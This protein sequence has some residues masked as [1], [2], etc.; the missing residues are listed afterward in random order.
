LRVS[1]RDALKTRYRRFAEREAAGNS[2]LYERLASGIA[3]SDAALGFLL[4]LPSERRQPNL[5]LAALRVT[6]PMPASVG[7]LE[8]RLA[9]DG[10][11]VSAVMLSRTT[12]TN[13]PNRC[14]VLLPLLARLPQPVALIEVGAS[15]GLCLIPDR[16]GYTYDGGPSL[17]PPSPAAPRLVCDITG[18]GPT[19]SQPK[20]AWA[21]GLDLNPLDVNDPAAMDWLRAL[22]WP[23]QTDR[24]DRL[25]RAIDV[26]RTDPPRVDRGDLMCD[27]EAIVAEV[28][29]DATPVVFHT[30]VLA[31]L[32]TDARDEFQGKMSDVDAHW[33]SVE[34][35]GVFPDIAARLPEPADGSRFVVAE[36]GRPV[37]LA[38]PHG[39]SL[40]WL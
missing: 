20:I 15:A 4:R 13:E 33:I 21:R 5:F 7:A 32:S 23:E 39:Q 24:L 14:A 6:G 3:D 38:G 37:A 27:L 11:A 10:A 25:N 12:Q 17:A 31:Y 30:A 18:T 40:H 29:D 36:N 35:P 34:A 28:P 16:Y 2:P 9:A 19:P 1:A 22:V 8:A 26:A